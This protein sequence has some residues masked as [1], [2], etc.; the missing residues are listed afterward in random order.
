M[1]PLRLTLRQRLTVSLT[2]AVLSSLLLAGLVYV[3]F[4]L[5]SRTYLGSERAALKA[6]LV[7]SQL[8][9]AGL[10]EV[11]ENSSWTL[12]LSGDGQI[13]W[14]RIY[15]LDGQLL[16]TYPEAAESHLVASADETSFLERPIYDD[17]KKVGT[18]RIA[19]AQGFAWDRLG[20]HS[21]IFSALLGASCLLTL[22]LARLLHRSFSDQVLDLAR[23]A[24]VVSEQ[25]D[26]S[27]RALRRSE[28]EVGLLVDTFN[29]MLTQIE[30]RDM[31]L[32]SE[33]ERTE[34]AMLAKSKFLATMS[35]ELRTP[36]NGILGMTG[37]LLDTELS[38]EQVEFSET[39][40]TSTNGLLAIINDILDFSKGEAGAFQ[41]E[42][43]PFD[44]ST[45]V[46][47]ALD[48]VGVTAAGK[49]L[50]LAALIHN[51]VPRKLIGD[52]ARLR[53][54]ILNLLSNALKFTHE[55]E[56]VLEVERSGAEPGDL[57]FSV[58]DTGIGIPS[59][60]LQ[61]LFKS[62]SQIDASNHR[63]YGGT[64][65]GLVISKQI[66]EA[67]GGTIFV[68]TE[69]GRG[70]TF[71]FR[72]H[73]PLDDQPQ[74]KNEIGTNN[75]RILVLESSATTQRFL[76]HAL[77][78]LAEL[79]WARSAA[80]TLSV[81]QQRGSDAFHAAIIDLRLI[82]DGD[83]GLARELE[84]GLLS[85]L[86]VVFQCSIASRVP[87]WLMSRPGRW[88]R[89][90]RPAL[91]SEI[92][93]ALQFAM[94][95]NGQRDER[96]L[97]R[98]HLFQLTQLPTDARVLVAEDHPVNQRITTRLLDKAGVHWQL[99][100][101]GL[102]VVEACRQQAFDLVLMDIQ[103]PEMDGLE[104]TRR[105][106]E[107][108]AQRGGRVPIVAMTASVLSD[109]EES[110]RRAGLN[111]Y[112]LKPFRFEQLHECLSRWLSAARVTDAA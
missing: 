97:R 18:L 71:G 28:D 92:T 73:L 3:P 61:S 104:A 30:L 68:N 62:F 38:G 47:E 69:E 16:A 27:I 17:G 81:L 86:P 91:S 109:D 87:D 77:E 33:V 4:D 20:V 6:S 74:P 46:R 98:N 13:D 112:L 55:G 48:T 76:S 57:R 22:A 78:G 65:L 19:N 102:E 2:F 23:A 64:G 25:N 53:Q 101:N 110:L 72:L 35:H 94:N 93:G 1:W 89:I 75:A 85:E 95:G 56:V 12:D 52:P 5:V 105:I 79:T 41:V 39:I 50:E 58:R 31:Q 111:G 51:E 14:A 83:D 84:T 80:E 36:I 96:R 99:A 43:I 106:R 37:L 67:M 70:S 32:Q 26:Y 88:T 9:N 107:L 103:M 54:V 60:R 44:L 90:G 29:H 100:S 8:S 108:E 40:Q 82:E 11:I 59:D 21:M 15:D 49:G 66:V 42:S 34:A 24:R 45:L 63:K 7:A 10:A